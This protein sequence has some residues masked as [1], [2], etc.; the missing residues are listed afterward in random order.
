MTYKDENKYNFEIEEFTEDD[1][2]EEGLDDK[3]KENIKNRMNTLLKELKEANDEF[4][5]DIS[6]NDM[7]RIKNAMGKQGDEYEH[8]IRNANVLKYIILKVIDK[9]IGYLKDELIDE[10]FVPSFISLPGV[11]TSYINYGAIYFF[12]MYLIKDKLIYYGISERFKIVNRKVIDIKNIKTIGKC[13]K[14]KK[15]SNGLSYGIDTCSGY[16]SFIEVDNG[17]IIY[18]NHLKNKYKDST[19]RFLE[20]LEEITG[21]KAIDEASLTKSDIF[22]LGAQKTIVVLLLVWCVYKLIQLCL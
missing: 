5:I 18:L 12:K 21:I 13:V 9:D 2:F 11:N 7:L 14:N 19:V 10:L 6:L 8:G 16:I 15:W 1:L 17:D 4:N 3:K 20:N 22:V